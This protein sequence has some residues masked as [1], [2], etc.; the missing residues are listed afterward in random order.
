[1]ETLQLQEY[2]EWIA[3]HLDEL[4]SQYA[5]QVV[6]IHQ[7]KV[8]IIGSSEV[9]VYREI[10]EEGLKPMPLVLRVPRVK[11]PTVDVG[12]LITH[13]P[14]VRGGRPR[15]VGTGVT[16]QRIVGW[17]KLGLSPEEIAEEF[18]HLTLAQVHAAL[19]YYH[20]NRQEI[21]SALTADEAEA[22]EL[23]QRHYQTA[24]GRR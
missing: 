17:Y 5:G 2:D 7:G 14:D 19:A 3:D 12:T 15:I 21:E 4:V 23:V 22:D 24:G 8:S 13:T 6:A 11:T 18:G 16:V 10:R 9:D 20:A 1:M